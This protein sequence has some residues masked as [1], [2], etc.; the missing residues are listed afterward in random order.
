MFQA[1]LRVRAVETPA[2]KAAAAARRTPTGPGWAAAAGGRAGPA[3]TFENVARGV[4]T[5]WRV[6]YVNYPRYH[7]P[8]YALAPM[9]DRGLFPQ[10]SPSSP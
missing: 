9:T 10:W 3:F 6:H 7:V 5:V 2:S 1:L 4:C 8:Y